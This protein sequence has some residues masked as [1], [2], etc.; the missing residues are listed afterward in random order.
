MRP[1]SSCLPGRACDRELRREDEP[2]ALEEAARDVREDAKVT[3]SEQR[4]SAARGS[5]A[6]SGR[7]VELRPSAYLWSIGASWSIVDRLRDR[8]NT[9]LN[10]SSEYWYM[11]SMTC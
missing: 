3:V 4:S 2:V 7:S 6:P 10:V 1:T 8:K 5:A 11:W 9:I